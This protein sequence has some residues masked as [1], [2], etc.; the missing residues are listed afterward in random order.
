M[1]ELVEMWMDPEASA[2]EM[3]ASTDQLLTDIQVPCFS[4]LMMASL[5]GSTDYPIR[6]P[7]QTEYLEALQQHTHQ[8]VH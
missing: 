1:N 8:A 5:S 4:S 3:E 6:L 2:E 7:Y